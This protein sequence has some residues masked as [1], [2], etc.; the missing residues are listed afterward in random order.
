[1]GVAKFDE[2]ALLFE[3]WASIVFIAGYTLISPWWR[4]TVGQAIV[5]LDA[6]LTVTLLPSALRYMFG[7]N[8]R[9][10]FFPWYTGFALTAVGLVT[11]WRLWVIWS[12]Q[13]DATPRHDN[14]P[15][16]TNEEEV[17]Q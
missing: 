8:P 16:F 12:V 2:W 6:A 10:G 11:L 15:L 14:S 9:A 4:Y 3:F 1:V 5:A 17:S 7:F 13:N